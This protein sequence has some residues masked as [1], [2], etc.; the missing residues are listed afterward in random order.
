MQR[1]QFFVFMHVHVCVSACLHVYSSKLHVKL[2]SH[3][4]NNKKYAENR[5]SQVI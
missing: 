2:F 4:K 3:V 1:I 5:Y